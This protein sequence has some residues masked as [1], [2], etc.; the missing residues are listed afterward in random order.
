MAKYFLSA[1][2]WIKERRFEVYAPA[3]YHPYMPKELVNPKPEP[4]VR[5]TPWKRA[6]VFRRDTTPFRQ[7]ADP[8]QIQRA[9]YTVEIM[10][11]MFRKKIEFQIE[12][13]D[14]IVEILD[15]VDRY[16]VSIETDISLGNQV[17]VDYARLVIEWRKE[18]YKH[19]FRYMNTNPTAKERLYPNQNS[20]QNVF[21]LMSQVGGVTND[22]SGLDPLRKKAHPPF[23]LE[24]II[25]KSMQDS[26]TTSQSLETEFGLSNDKQGGFIDDG[27]DFN[28]DDF[29]KKS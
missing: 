16:L 11:D 25:P 4:L 2:E 29:L 18:L 14:D 28:F 21:Y 8:N 24:E 23:N 9:S 26:K 15:G 22:L 17:I 3:F 20:K 12:N 13:D 6:A 7:L 27:R 19:Y 10:L 1:V 5:A